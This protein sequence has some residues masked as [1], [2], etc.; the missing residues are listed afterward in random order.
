LIGG[1]QNNRPSKMHA[2]SKMVENIFQELNS[3]K[4]WFFNK[5]TR[6]LF[7]WKRMDID[8]NKVY[9]NLPLTWQSIH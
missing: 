2:K 4:E 1:Q 6:E 5:K 9:P 8:L 3:E 7:V